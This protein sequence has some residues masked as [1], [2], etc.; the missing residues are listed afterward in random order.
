LYN[1]IAKDSSH[2]ASYLSYIT[3]RAPLPRIIDVEDGLHNVNRGLDR[4][5]KGEISGG[6]LVVDLKTNQ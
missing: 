3:I 1:R 4:M 2:I 6:K 5:R